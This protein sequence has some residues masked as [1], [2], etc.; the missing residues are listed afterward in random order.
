VNLALALILV[1]C[2]TFALFRQGEPALALISAVGRECYSE[3]LVQEATNTVQKK[4]RMTV[5]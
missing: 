1:A 5:A 3:F 4:P 2:S